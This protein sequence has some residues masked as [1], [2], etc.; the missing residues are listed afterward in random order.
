[1]DE[2][3]ASPE[4]RAD[5]AAGDLAD[6][7]LD[8][9][10]GQVDLLADEIDAVLSEVPDQVADRG[11]GAGHGP[12]FAVPPSLDCHRCTSRSW[13]RALRPRPSRV[14]LAAGR[15]APASAPRNAGWPGPGQPGAPPYPRG[16]NGYATELRGSKD[17]RSSV[18][19]ETGTPRA[20]DG[21]ASSRPPAGL[22]PARAGG[23]PPPASPR[24][25]GR[26]L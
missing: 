7:L 13:T 16:C 2:G 8:L 23:P 5:G 14:C 4:G 11:R 20:G 3:D 19:R 18:S 9:Q 10:L 12:L 15:V 6:G 22:G 25:P 17:L 1:A 21:A 24:R 26:G